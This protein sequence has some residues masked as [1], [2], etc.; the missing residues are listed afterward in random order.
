M[1]GESLARIVYAIKP[2]PKRRKHKYALIR[3][4]GG[5]GGISASSALMKFGGTA[6][7]DVKLQ[8]G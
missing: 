4:R 8:A 3:K 2:K 5:E 7:G 1:S 6:R